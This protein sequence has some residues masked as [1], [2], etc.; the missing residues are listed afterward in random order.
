MPLAGLAAMDDTDSQIQFADID[1]HDLPVDAWEGVDRFHLLVG[2]IRRR[3]W[4]RCLRNERDRY[5][6]RHQRRHNEGGTHGQ[7]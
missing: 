2:D 4:R 7:D 3:R 1:A 6:Y 5:R